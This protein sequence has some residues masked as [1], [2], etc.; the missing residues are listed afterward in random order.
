ME[1]NNTML[2]IMC[3]FFLILYIISLMNNYEQASKKIK[4]R[5]H[6]EILADQLATLLT[7]DHTLVN[8][9]GS[10]PFQSYLLN[11]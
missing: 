3:L 9:S 2:I 6:T 4:G 1:V 5:Y 8:S 7:P 11:K 10:P